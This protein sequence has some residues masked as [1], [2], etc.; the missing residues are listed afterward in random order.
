MTYSESVGLKT[1]GAS[2][3]TCRLTDA[4]LKDEGVMVYV[5]LSCRA[6]QGLILMHATFCEMTYGL[7]PTAEAVQFAGNL[8]H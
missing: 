5:H 8:L 1:A 4:K 3:C 6:V 2:A 7:S